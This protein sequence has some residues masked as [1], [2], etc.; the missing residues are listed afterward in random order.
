[1]LNGLMGSEGK[2][3][4]GFMQQLLAPG[5]RDVAP[6]KNRRQQ[7]LPTANQAPFQPWQR[8]LKKGVKDVGALGPDMLKYQQPLQHEQN[9]FGQLLNDMGLDQLSLSPDSRFAMQYASAQFEVNY[10]SIQ[11]IQTASGVEMREVNFSFKASFEY[12]SLS[13]GQGGGEL[14]PF[15]PVEEAGEGEAVDPLQRL[16]DFYSPEKTAERILDFALSFFP[17]SSHFEEKGDTEEG[18]RDF[19]DMMGNAIQKGFD[20]A[21]NLLGQLPEKV[22]EDVDKTNDLVFD[23]LGDFVKEGRDPQKA[24]AYAKAQAFQFQMS[25]EYTEVHQR[26]SYYDRQGGHEAPPAPD[27]QHALD[28][29]V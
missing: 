3:L 9:P 22:Q 20:E 24:D 28:S 7:V 6:G 29:V 26:V 16:M 4:Q 23:G 12:L 1:M 13:A 15:A 19:A 17:G 2:N 14:D 10:R 11:Q 18:R 8:G 5:H 27:A 25:M 21:L